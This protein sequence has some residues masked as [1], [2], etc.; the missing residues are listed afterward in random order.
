MSSEQRLREAVELL[1]TFAANYVKRFLEKA[2][3]R[4]FQTK[5]GAWLA[6]LSPGKKYGAEFALY[7][8]TAFFDSRL[9]EN[10]KLK[11]FVKEVGIDV[12]PEISKRMINGVREE[13]ILSAVSPAEKGLADLLLS[14]EDKE[15]IELLRWLYE[16]EASEKRNLL[17]LI[18][19]LSS[20]QITRLLGLPVEERE[21]FSRLLNLPEEP[22]EKA[23]QGPSEPTFGEV[24]RQDMVKGAER[25]RE[26]KE[27]MRQ[28]RKGGRQ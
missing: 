24:L 27:R 23:D 9:A 25:L 1:P 6:S 20:E 12:A 19:L 22:K 11:K 13:V 8:L 18:S 17:S 5:T 26:V 28:R 4:V 2:Y 3:D 14:L 15:L 21:K 10:T 16:K 7:A